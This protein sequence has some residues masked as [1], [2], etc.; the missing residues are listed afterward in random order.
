MNAPASDGPTTSTQHQED[1]GRHRLGLRRHM[2]RSGHRTDLARLVGFGA[3]IA[4][5]SACGSTSASGGNSSGAGSTV[6]VGM[7]TVSGSS[8]Q[9]LTEPDGYTLYYNTNDTSTTASC[10]GA[11]AGTWPPLLM[12]SGQP[13]SASTLPESLTTAST[14]NGTQVEYD[15]HPLYRYSGDSGSDQANGEGKGGIWFVATPSLGSSSSTASPSAAAIA[16]G[17]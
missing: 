16:P 10:T 8:E 5:L 6:K 9:V 13:T 1:R 3:A 2:G 15:G 4:L 12:A 17:Y 14:G 11:C 7:A